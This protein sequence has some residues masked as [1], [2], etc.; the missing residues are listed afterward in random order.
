MLVKTDI[1]KHVTK[2]VRTNFMVG[3]KGATPNY[4]EITSILPSD[5]T[6]EDYAWL[7]STQNIKE[8]VDELE[9][10]EVNEYNFSVSNKK[11]GD[12]L[13]IDQDAIDDDQYG[14]LLLRAKGMGAAV[15]RFIDK[16]IFEKLAAGF[17]GTGYDGKTFF[18][19]DHNESGTN[20]DNKGSSAL[21]VAALKA[22][23][24]AMEKFTDDKGDPMGITPTHLIV[25]PDLRWTAME[26]LDSQYYPEEG[27]TTAKLAKNVVQ[28]ALKLVVSPYLTDTNNWYLISVSD[29]VKPL[30]WQNRLDPQLKGPIYD[31]DKDISKWTLKFRGAAAYGRWQYAYGATV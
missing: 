9:E 27:T 28:G 20:Q 8:W 15:A 7:G 10:G 3:L 31:E 4:T 25:P 23:I 18:A 22:A 19:D 11:Y 21:S 5:A 26:I 13:T 2:G 17:T 29:V 14:Q 24:T 12:K 6:S 16:T 30:I 1:P